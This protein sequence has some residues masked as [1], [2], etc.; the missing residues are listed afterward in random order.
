MRRALSRWW[1]DFRDYRLACDEVMGLNL[2]NRALIEAANPRRFRHLADD[3]LAAKQL[4]ARAG[5]PTPRTIHT[6]HR[7]GDLPACLT[8]L[9]EHASF[10]VKPARGSGGDGILVV[11]GKTERG[12]LLA[13]G[14]E[15]SGERMRK[16]LAEIIFGAYSRGNDDDILVEERLIP[17]HQLVELSPAGLCD[18]RVLVLHGQPF[19]AMMRV[20]TDGSRGRANLHAGGIGISLDLADGSVTSARSGGRRIERHPDTGVQLAGLQ[21]PHFWELLETSVRAARAFPL[22]YLG[23]DLCVDEVRGPLVLEVNVRAG[24]EIQNICRRGIPAMVRAA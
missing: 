16:H 11:T 21:V 8:V 10:V 22:G 4:L 7:L 24:L 9:G 15:L 19:A 23:V 6:C 5:V 3:K 18:V 13:G 2:R 14:H 17:H 20:P 1:R 12:F